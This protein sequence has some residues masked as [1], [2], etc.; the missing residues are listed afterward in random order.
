MN[1][2]KLEKCYAYG[3]L[4]ILT[5]FRIWNICIWMYCTLHLPPTPIDLKKCALAFMIFM[6][7]IVV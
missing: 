5:G 2:K 1:R 3:N 4:M 6:E 7:Y